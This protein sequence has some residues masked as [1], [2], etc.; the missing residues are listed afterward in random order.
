MNILPSTADSLKYLVDWYSFHCFMTMLLLLLLLSA[1]ALVVTIVV[2]A[3]VHYGIVEAQTSVTF[4]YGFPGCQISCV[5]GQIV[6]PFTLPSI[7]PL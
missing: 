1:L 7:W 5:C 2:V 3:A 4:T 6:T